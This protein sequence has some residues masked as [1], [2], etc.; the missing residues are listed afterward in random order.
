[1]LIVTDVAVTADV[2]PVF[3]A[4]SVT[5]FAARRKRTVPSVEH[6]TVTGTVK[7]ENA[8]TV[9]LQFAVPVLEKSPAASPETVSLNVTPYDNDR[10][11]EGDEGSVIVAVG[12]VLSTAGIVT[13]TDAGDPEAMFT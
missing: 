11:D 10:D 2:G 6:V 8:P 5:E 13:V 4:A 9:M 12:G 3:D 7:P 1:M